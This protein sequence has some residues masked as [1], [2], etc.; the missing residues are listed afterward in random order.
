VTPRTNPPMN[1]PSARYHASIPA[2]TNG[3]IRREP[4]KYARYAS[5]VPGGPRNPLGARALYLFQNGEDTLYRIHGACE[6]QYL[7]KQV[8]SGCIRLLDQDVIHL[9]DQVRDGVPV[10][11]LTAPESLGGR[12][13]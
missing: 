13:Y 3:M 5:G 12:I 10:R 7:G 8:S 6:P 11:V 9:H 1:A 2:N 4:G